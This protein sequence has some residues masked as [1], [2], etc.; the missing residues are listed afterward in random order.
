MKN[1]TKITSVMLALFLALC[2]VSCKNA[3]SSQASG[4]GSGNASGKAV[5]AS[6]K[7][8]VGGSDVTYTFYKDKTLSYA[9][10]GASVGGTYTGDVS[11]DGMGTI[12]LDGGN[13]QVIKYDWK[14][15][16][17]KITIG[18]SYM[19]GKVTGFILTRI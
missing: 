3:A 9:N 8:T 18:K 17:N 7:G 10:S 13:G 6:F 11:T 1:L 19:E 16:G 5:V 14:L 12:T 4:E 2:F 15:E